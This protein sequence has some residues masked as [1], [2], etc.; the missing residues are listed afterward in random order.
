MN[1]LSSIRALI[2]QFKKNIQKPELIETNVRTTR[3]VKEAPDC[4]HLRNNYDY[5]GLF[6]FS[7]GLYNIKILRNC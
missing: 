5:R 7:K 1:P 4:M 2:T 3:D 6:R